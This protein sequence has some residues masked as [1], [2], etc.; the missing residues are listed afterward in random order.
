MK[1]LFIQPSN[2]MG[3]IM[4][5]ARVF[6]YAQ[7]PL[8][9]LYIAALLE[10]VGH[11][12]SLLDAWALN[13][14]L[15]DV[16]DYLAKDR[17]DVIGISTLTSS[18]PFTY[19]L[20]KYI[21]EH[22]PETKVILGNI[23][24]T[25]YHKFFLEQGCADVVVLGEGELIM[26]DLL[27]A[28]EARKDLRAVPGIAFRDNGEV[29]NT[30]PGPIVQN[31]DDLPLPARH[32]APMDRYENRHFVSQTDGNYVHMTTTRGC[33]YGCTFC[34][35]NAKRRYRTRNPVLVVDEIELLVRKYNTTFIEFFDPLFTVDKKNVMGICDEIVRRQ[36]PVEWQCT[37]H[38][39]TVS[40]ELLRAMKR[41]GCRNVAYGIET[42]SQDLLT[43]VKKGSTPGKVRSAIEMTRRAG[44][45]P[46]GL[47]MLGLPGETREDSLKT[48]E[49]SLSLPIDFAQFAILV[50]YPGSEI[51]D[52]L[53]AAGQIDQEKSAE[54][55]VENWKRFSAYLGFTD[56]DPLFVPAGRT[57]RELKELQRTAVR[58]FFL[59][60][61]QILK[62]MKKFRPRYWR[63]YLEGIRTVFLAA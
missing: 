50:P 56:L 46:H 6:V 18:G 48:I 17:W 45:N 62:E 11:E 55:K 43:A 32:L 53:V 23:H 16:Y 8:G 40:E 36:I 30:G 51:Y 57:A 37:A 5:G 54:E 33:P 41:A 29:V 2:N 28:L 47:F 59:R 21:K 58:E 9:P 12:V 49:L 3:E 22:Y 42:A 19:R 13:Y 34:V 63:S 60:P 27:R 25:V 26:Q 7:P 20:G 10:K 39:Q 52:R 38:V 44:L 31:L 14:S 61:R 24:A 35:V 15:A 4:G 1:I